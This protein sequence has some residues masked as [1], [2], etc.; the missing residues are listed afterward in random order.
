[1]QRL[2]YI[3]ALSATLVALSAGIAA[4]WFLAGSR[5][6][7]ET[8]IGGGREVRSSGKTPRARK[9]PIKSSSSAEVR[10]RIL[11][12]RI[13][14]LEKTIRN[15]KERRAAAKSDDLKSAEGKEL[16]DRLMKIP[17]GWK[18]DKEMERLGEKKLASFTMEQMAELSPKQFAVP[19]GCAV[20]FKQNAAQRA[21]RLA[22]LESLDQSGMS[23][24]ERELHCAYLENYAKLVDSMT[25]WP[26]SKEDYKVWTYGETIENLGAFF[27]A[28]KTGNEAWPEEK[29]MLVSQVSK[30]FEVPENDVLD[31]MPSLDEVDGLLKANAVGW[32]N[33]VKE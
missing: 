19:E 31:M 27:A 17:E 18:R 22:F 8:S 14:L 25:K 7:D 5:G 1:M 4:G 3:C 20:R 29:K 30:A 10:E 9:S 26:V 2:S 32:F 11:E 13:E 15:T 33:E 16:F 21:S 24:E 28:L 23:A 6:P 12:K